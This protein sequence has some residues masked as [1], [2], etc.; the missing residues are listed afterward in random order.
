MK[1]KPIYVYVT[2]FFPSPV[3]WRGAHGYDFV[4]ALINTGKYDVFV[5]K[6]GDGTDY[7]FA[8]VKVHTFR[9]RRLPSNIYPMLFKRGNQRRFLKALSDVGISVEDVAICHANTANYGIYPLA[10]KSKNKFC[11]ALLH[12]HDLASFGLNIGIL[13][14]CLPYNVIEYKILKK[15]HE[16]MDC[17]IFISEACKRSFL[18]APNTEWTVYKD[19]KRQMRGLGLFNCHPVNVKHGIV[20]HNGV[21]ATVFRKS[22]A[23]DATKHKNR[24]SFVIG[25]IGNF[26]TLKDQITLL[27]AVSLINNPKCKVIFVGSGET[28]GECEEYAR[29]HNISAEFRSEVSHDTLPNFYHELDLFVLPSYFEGF[30]CVFLEAWAC[31]VPF[32]TCFGQGMDDFI[33]EEDSDMWLFKP[34][35]SVQLSERIRFFLHH[36]P[37]QLLRAEIDEAKIVMQFVQKNLR[38]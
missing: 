33:R 35:D 17:H 29:A 15:M 31:G 37:K 24:D 2:P 13:R 30:G 4:R 12:H 7:E 20:L 34:R 3:S 38:A 36:R 23:H 18:A 11:K 9:S 22:N 21:D 14:H 5:F 26:Q 10:I 32:M 27:K 1:H 19:Y 28:M 25:C 8:G 16:A 6:E